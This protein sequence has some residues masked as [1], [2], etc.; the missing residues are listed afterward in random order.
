M[1]TSTG[2]MASAAPNGVS[3]SAASSAAAACK[4]A[5]AA[6]SA[7][8]GGVSTKPKLRGSIWEPA[9]SLICRTTASRRAVAIA[10]REC[11]G[12]AANV[13][14]EYRRKHS[15]G[16]SSGMLM[17][18]CSAV[19]IERQALASTV[20]LSLFTDYRRYGK[21]EPAS[22]PDGA[23]VLSNVCSTKHTWPGTSCTTLALVS[24]C[25]TDPTQLQR[26]HT[27]DRVM[28]HVLGG[29]AV[30]NK[31][32]AINRD[33]CFC[34]VGRQ[35]ALAHTSRR[36]VKD[37]VLFIDGQPSMQRQDDPALCF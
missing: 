11:R 4:P 3:A 23:R 14:S 31:A 12:K 1:W 37:Q 24:T 27:R 28:H 33:G 36:T 18:I 21:D 13:A 6:A 2:N 16:H 19:G 17:H 26:C 30:S 15:P 9:R 32:D 22:T 34:H 8:V 5:I 7:S 20:A 29:A 35:D 10:G 25:L